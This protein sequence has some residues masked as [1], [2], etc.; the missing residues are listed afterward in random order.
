LTAPF[1]PPAPVLVAFEGDVA[2]PEV[3]AGIRAGRP[4]V[5]LYRSLNCFSLEQVR[6]LTDGVHA[7]AATGGFPPPIVSLDQEG[8]QL[9]AVGAA[10]P[11]PGNLALAA[12]RS[13]ELAEAVGNAIG[14]ELAALGVTVNFAPDC[15]LATNLENP[16]VGTRSFGDDPDLAARLA[17]AF[18]HGH[19]TAGVATTAKHFPGGGDRAIDPHYG[20]P[21]SQHGLERLR[22]VEL[23][24]FKAAIDAGCRL[25]MGAHVALPAIDGLADRPVMLS[26][27]I[28]VDLLR[29][30]LGFE[31]VVVSDA[32]DMGALDQSRVVMDAVEALH[33]GVDLLLAGP[34]QAGRTDLLVDIDRAFASRSGLAG[35]S[36]PMAAAGGAAASL[37]EPAFRRIDGL[38]RWLAT[39]TGQRPSISVFAGAQH[40]ALALE[41]A[42]RSVT[43]VFDRTGLLP[44]RADPD[45]RVVVVVPRPADLT[46]ADTSS[47]VA[48]E[49]GAALR[50]A[51]VGVDEIRV[52]IDPDHGE[53]ASTAERIRGA[54]IA[55]VGTINARFHRG[56]AAIAEAARA[57]GVPTIVV[58]LRMPDDIEVLPG[59]DAYVCTYSIQPPAVTALVEVLT[60]R[61]Q[62]TGQLPIRVAIP[63]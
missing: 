6:A 16:S 2:P 31:G 47:S 33:S 10:T 5:T 27:R 34:A 15:D 53:I 13:P 22:R 3:L 54:S 19:Q 45:R 29:G 4:G 56:Q 30:E 12:T 7:A 37:A 61:L 41:V 23:P 28:L 59:V 35:G 55:I 38:R 21:V 50:E 52:S 26:S 57:A 32:L 14:T 24:P 11:F 40:E 20:L 43:R 25:V 46:P 9:M 8:G 49:L 17:A 63:A 1:F 36:L 60:G 51:G 18:V 62:A 39:Q 48:I 58:A 42:R 44:L